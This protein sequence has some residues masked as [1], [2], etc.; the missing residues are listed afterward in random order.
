MRIFDADGR[1]G[2]VAMRPGWGPAG[3]PGGATCLALTR[4]LL[5]YVPM[6]SRT[7]LLQLEN[8]RMLREALS[9]RALALAVVR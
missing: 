6:D 7:S 1:T 9:T 2:A 3:T 5:C 4:R 8:G